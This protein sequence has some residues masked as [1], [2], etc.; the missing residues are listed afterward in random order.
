MSPSPIEAENNPNTS[1]A[2][3]VASLRDYP[4]EL[5]LGSNLGALS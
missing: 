5:G 4:S 1:R 2:D 3:L